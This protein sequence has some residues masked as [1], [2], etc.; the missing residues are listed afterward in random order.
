MLRSCLARWGSSFFGLPDNYRLSLHE[1]IFS[2]SYHSQGGFTQDIVYN[3][4]VYLRNFYL[5]KLISVKEEERKAAQPKSNSP[6]SKGIS[7]PG[8]SRK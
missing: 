6:N 4:P 7:R 5:K 2:L 3:L 1:E 8:I